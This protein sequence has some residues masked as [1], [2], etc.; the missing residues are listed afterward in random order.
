MIQAIKIYLYDYTLGFLAQ[1][2]G[3]YVFKY[4]E[5]FQKSGLQPAPLYMDTKRAT[6]SFPRL[7]YTS[8]AGLPGLISDSI[9]DYYGTQVIQK[10]YS[11]IGADPLSITPL[12]K[13]AYIG[14]RGFGALRFAPAQSLSSGVGDPNIELFTLWDESRK[15]L[16]DDGPSKEI[17]WV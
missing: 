4:D 12:D 2:N 1:D 17:S 10:Y 3:K 16:N 6:Y 11:S 14:E 9:P 13:L 5:K 8:F 15:V 7:N